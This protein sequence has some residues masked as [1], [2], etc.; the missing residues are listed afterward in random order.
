MKC[1][2]GSVLEIS[3]STGGF[4]IEQSLDRRAITSRYE[5]AAKLRDELKALQLRLDAASQ[6]AEKAKEK[7][8]QQRQLRLGQRVIITPNGHRGVVCG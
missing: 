3:L 7:L 5:E 1:Q 6:K 2:S 8:K 4:C